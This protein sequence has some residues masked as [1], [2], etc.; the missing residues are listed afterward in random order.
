MKIIRTA[1]R[2]TV[3][4]YVL[5]IDQS[6]VDDINNDITH[7]STENFQPLTLK[8]VE[9]IVSG[10]DGEETRASEKLSFSN[11][12]LGEYVHAWVNDAIWDCEYTEID[13]YT[14][15]WEDEIIN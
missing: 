3:E 14:N 1:Y 13:G 8:E 2:C 12:N 7:W 11:Y 9:D 15:D 4:E 5:F 6:L 10:E